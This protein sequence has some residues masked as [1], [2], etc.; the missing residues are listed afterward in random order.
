M[1][2]KNVKK[3]IALVSAAVMTAGMV[4]CGNTNVQADNVSKEAAVSGKLS[5][6]GSTS[7]EKLVK[8]LKET[9]A[10]AEPGVTVSAEFVG[11]G[12]GIEQVLAGTVDIGNSSRNLKDAEKKKGAVENIVAIDGIAMVV[13][14]ANKITDLSKED[15]I[16]IYTGEVT[17]WFEVGG[18]NEPIVVIGREAGSGTRGAFEEILGIE[19]MCA[20]ASELD[21][22]G[23]VMAKVSATP[24]AIGYVSLDALNETVKAVSLEGIVATEENILEGKY[25]LS[26]PFV[27]A[28]KGTIE[29]QNEVVQAFFEYVLS[30]EGQAVVQ[31]VG[32]I[33]VK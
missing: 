7:M 32:L 23:A 20:Y 22:T 4:A 14:T 19:E 31:Q 24:G 21:S 27:M 9:F 5:I 11:S 8:A 13:D 10:Q 3:L 28:T 12:A 16:K 29:E 2:K 26:R 17:N 30:E 6:A 25:F 33:P 1:K 18:E 15:L